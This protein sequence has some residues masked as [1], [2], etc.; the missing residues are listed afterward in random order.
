MT[1]P[2]CIQAY[3]TGLTRVRTATVETAYGERVESIQPKKIQADGK[4][5]YKYHGQ[6]LTVRTAAIHPNTFQTQGVPSIHSHSQTR[7]SLQLG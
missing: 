7:N 2:S 1:K 5:I 6:V 3:L 4:N